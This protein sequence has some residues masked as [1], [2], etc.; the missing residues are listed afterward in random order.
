MLAAL[1]VQSTGVWK[2]PLA[3]TITTITLE[4]TSKRELA[5]IPTE[6]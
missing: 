2:Q 3:Q 5:K 6:N 4:K 1:D